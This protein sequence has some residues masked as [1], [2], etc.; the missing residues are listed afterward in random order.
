MGASPGTDLVHHLHLPLKHFRSVPVGHFIHRFQLST[1]RFHLLR[2]TSM[3]VTTEQGPTS[4]M[5]GQLRLALGQHLLELLL[6]EG[7]P[8][9]DVGHHLL[10]ASSS[11]FGRRLAGYAHEDGRERHKCD[12]NLHG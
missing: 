11:G 12:R 8:F 3:I 6:T 7:L 10:P 4:F 5:I 1:E 2:N 9:D